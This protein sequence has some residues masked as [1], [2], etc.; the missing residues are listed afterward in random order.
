MT[1]KSVQKLQKLYKI[2]FGEA[3]SHEEALRIGTDL[4]R[5]VELVYRDIQKEDL[6]IFLSNVT[7]PVQ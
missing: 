6:G 3:I 1:N 2:E 4:V 5:V 7:Q